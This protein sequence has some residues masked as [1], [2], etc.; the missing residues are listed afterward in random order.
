M[1]A[2]RVFVIWSHPL[3]RETVSLLL[4]HPL[5]ELVGTTSDHSAARTLIDATR[6]D[7]VI[8]EQINGEEQA[9]EETVAILQQGSKVIQLSLANNELRLYHRELRIVEKVGD[10]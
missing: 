8:I 6:P 9:S 4:S 1:V 10:L 7:V 2:Q 5:V 3:F